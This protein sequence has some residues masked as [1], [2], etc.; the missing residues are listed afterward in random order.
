MKLTQAQQAM[1][2]G[3]KGEVYAKIMKTLVMYGECFG[4][5]EMLP[6]TSDKG[7][8]VTSFGLSMMK[9]VY[10]LMDQLIEAGAISD[11][12]FSVDPRPLDPK[13][14][15][16]LLQ[17]VFFKV[18]YS[19]QSDYEGQL[20]K[21]GLVANNAF[22]CTC[23]MDE[24]GNAPKEGEVLSWAESSAV[25][26]ANSVLGAKCNRNSG[27]IELFGSIAGCVPKFGLLTDEGRKATWIIEI[28]TTKKPEAQ[29]LG[30][31]IGMAVM[32]DVPF[33][34]GLD[35]WIGTELNQPT[36]DYLKDMGA[37]TA[38]NGAVGLYHVENLTPEAKRLGAD[39]IA[40]NARV[41][42]ITDET[43]RNTKAGYPVM[44]KDENAKPKLCF[45][46]CPHLSKQQLI[47]WT[48]KLKGELGA[49]KVKIPTVFTAA[50]AVVTEFKKTK[51]FKELSDMGVVVSS[52]CPL[53]YMNN[54]LCGKMPVITNS[55][56]LRTYTTSKYCT[57]ADI[58]SAITKGVQ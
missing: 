13:V 44:W 33:I 32:E 56:K 16:N 10:K 53:M 51:E 49:E 7:H 39:I 25:V 35:K 31:A 58:L 20:R 26:Y 11:Q 29:I 9:P 46:G 21:L 5:S 52:I 50:P 40:E 3:E 48:K 42:K 27:I 34:K 38:S 14:P 18:M 37:A 15:S 24:V 2:D 17:D 6:I 47:D 43:L 57:D 1:L 22:T 54:P 45:V 4:A 8:L 19:K 36:K 28:E 41:L 30:S 12:K 23:Y 55:N